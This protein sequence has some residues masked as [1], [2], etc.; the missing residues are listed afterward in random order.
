[1]RAR[2]CDTLAAVYWGPVYAYVRLTHRAAPE[3]AEDLAQG[4]FAEAL[5]RDLFARYEPERARF[6]TYLRTCVDAFV[7]NE[8]KAER[9]L[10]RGG[11]VTPLPIDVAGLEGR[12]A[13]ESDPDVIFHQEWVRGVLTLALGR[14]RERCE[15]S[16]RRSHL[17]LFERY[18]VA[19]AAD[20]SPPTYAELAS[21]LGMTTAQVTNRLAAVRREF[22]AAVLDT[23]RDLCAS[24]DEFRAEARAL[25]GVEVQ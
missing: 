7:A 15:R 25:L 8:R 11:G 24:D 6:R 2:A 16:G 18:D 20:R 14:L 22:R 3:D 9:R 4:F 1:V 13:S 17:A 23:L 12:L 5:R 19:G 10:K 21:E